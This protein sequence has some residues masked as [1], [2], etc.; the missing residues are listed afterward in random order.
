MG[1]FLCGVWVVSL[2]FISLYFPVSQI[3]LSAQFPMTGKMF[4]FTIS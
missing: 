1:G 2:I 4:I 3:N